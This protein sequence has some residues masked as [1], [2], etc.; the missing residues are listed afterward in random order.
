M[1][2]YKPKEEHSLH[3]V[4]YRH[5]QDC[6]PPLIRINP[7]ISPQSECLY[8]PHLVRIG[9][10]SLT[11]ATYVFYPAFRRQSD[12]IQLPWRVFIANLAIR[13]SVI[14]HPA[15][16]ATLI[17]HLSRMPQWANPTP[18]KVSLSRTRLH[19]YSCPSSRERPVL[20]STLPSWF[21]GFSKSVYRTLHTSRI[22]HYCRYDKDHTQ[23]PW[24]HDHQTPSRVPDHCTSCTGNLS[25]LDTRLPL[26]R[27]DERRKCTENNSFK[28]NTSSFLVVGNERW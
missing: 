14:P 3:W 24:H 9:V 18:T 20:I 8:P 13:I 25:W 10:L 28:R 1:H 12:Q 7:T 15:Y 26:C 11:F 17:P 22:P 2:I 27:S 21:Q 23:A 19:C 5:F 16:I 4:Q 6:I